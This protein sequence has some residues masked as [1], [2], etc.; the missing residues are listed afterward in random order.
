MTKP[1]CLEAGGSGGGGG[2]IVEMAAQQVCAVSVLVPSVF[3]FVDC[4]QLGSVA[5]SS[6]AVA[7]DLPSHALVYNT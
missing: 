2:D 6:N 1:A 5:A 3:F 7:G 4:G